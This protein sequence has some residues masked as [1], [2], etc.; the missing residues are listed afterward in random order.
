MIERLIIQMLLSCVLSLH[1][2]IIF[3]QCDP[4]TGIV[5]VAFLLV[6]ILL[7]YIFNTYLAHNTFNTAFTSS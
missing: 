6:E 1:N 4:P 3:R 2:L 5:I 7:L